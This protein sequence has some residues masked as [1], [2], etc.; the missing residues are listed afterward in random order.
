M[1]SATSGGMLPMTDPDVLKSCSNASCSMYRGSIVSSSSVSGFCELFQMD[2]EHT[3][4][5]QATTVMRGRDD[6][7]CCRSSKRSNMSTVLDHLQ[8][9][10]ALAPD[11]LQVVEAFFEE[12][13]AQCPQVPTD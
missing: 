12:E 2:T 10:F 3:Y 5:I 6:T 8:T 9:F 4:E 13:S 7:A 1:M 11:P